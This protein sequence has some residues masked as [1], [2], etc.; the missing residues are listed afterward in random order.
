MIKKLSILSL[1][2]ITFCFASC[3]TSGQQKS[4]IRLENK[5]WTLTEINNEKPL[6]SVNSK[7]HIEF[8]VEEKKLSG[9][10]GCNRFSAPY[11]LSDNNKIRIANILSTRRACLDNDIEGK[12]F[13]SLKNTESY[14]IESN[15]LILKDKTGRCIAKFQASEE[16]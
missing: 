14:C 2:L 10:S 11:E 15:T 6:V 1:I 8:S 9:Y 16:K 3:K 4:T 7:A 12:L 5:E 13:E